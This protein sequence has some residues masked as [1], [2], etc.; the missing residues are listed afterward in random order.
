[1]RSIV[2]ALKFWMRTSA[3]STRRFTMSRASGFFRSRVSERLPVFMAMNIGERRF[4]CSGPGT[5]SISRD[6]SPPFGCSILITSAP[7]RAR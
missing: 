7:S 5:A 1:M 3:R 2:P 4:S 6:W